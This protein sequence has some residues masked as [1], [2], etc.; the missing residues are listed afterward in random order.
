MKKVAAA[1]FILGF[2]ISYH[3]KNCLMFQNMNIL[4]K[5][6]AMLFGLFVICFPNKVSKLLLRG[7]FNTQISFRVSLYYVYHFT[8]WSWFV[9][10]QKE[11][12]IIVICDDFHFFYVL[13]F[14]Y[15]KSCRRKLK[16][17]R[18][19]H[20]P[21]GGEYQCTRT[22]TQCQ[23]AYR[24]DTV[25]VRPTLKTHF[26]GALPLSRDSQKSSIFEEFSVNF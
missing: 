22:L 8:H 17:E 2:I 21:P 25:S 12:K 3:D 6:F 19:N 10:S 20:K 14:L 26:S 1:A 11:C 4:A 7:A 9:W 13:L 5:K 16:R 15:Q 18:S 24:T 23:Y